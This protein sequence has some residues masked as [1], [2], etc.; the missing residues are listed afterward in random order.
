[1]EISLVVAVYNE[2]QV[3]PEYLR[4]VVP[5]LEEFTKD[6]EIIF[7]MDP[8][9]DR[10]EEIIMEHR[11][12][13]PR[14]KLLRFSRR[15]GRTMSVLAGL[16]RSTGDAVVVMDVDL[17]D[18][19]EVIREMVAKWREG[20]DVVLA[21]RRTRKDG[22]LKISVA[23]LG[24]RIISKLADV[25]IPIDTGDFRLMN[26]RVVDEVCRLKEAHG[27]LK[28]MV[29]AVGFR[30]TT[31]QFDRPAR[32]HGK[33]K[34]GLF[35]GI[36]EGLNGFFC[37]SNTLLTFSSLFGFAVAG[38][39]FLLAVAYAILKMA[40]APF[41]MGNP[42]IVILILFLGGIQLITIGIL[43]AYIGRI[44]DEVKQRPKFIVDRAEGFED[45]QRK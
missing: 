6:F 18:P 17:Q 14:C 31:V 45:I 36:R 19:P 26:R 28:G 23:K 38:F 5:V 4:R 41:P 1:M 37:F 33:T 10:T 13:D 2:E 22:L 7:A 9:S 25:D 29:A 35:G 20:Y 44:Y 34:Y 39:S 21:R 42:T 43:G 11:R 15:F 3:I 32:T 12:R 24:Y 27:F 40:G 8:S 16:Q 30:Q